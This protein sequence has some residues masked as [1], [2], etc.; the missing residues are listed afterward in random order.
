MSTAVSF[1][2]KCH[3]SIFKMIQICSCFLFE[4]FYS[5]YFEIYL[6][7][8]YI[9]PL[10]QMQEVSTKKKDPIH[11]FFSPARSGIHFFMEILSAVT[12]LSM[13]DCQKRR[14]SQ[15]RLEAHPIYT[16]SLKRWRRCLMQMGFKHFSKGM[17]WSQKRTHERFSEMSVS[18]CVFLFLVADGVQQVS[19]DFNTISNYPG[20]CVKG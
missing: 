12:D 14:F 13:L 5:L 18:F 15:K 8:Q 1:R 20:G 16:S 2:F 7:L 9:D 3:C 4:I 17:R 6:H 10:Q 11:Y 19:L